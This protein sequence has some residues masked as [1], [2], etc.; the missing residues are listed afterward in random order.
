MIIL[1]D[2]LLRDEVGGEDME[3]DGPPASFEPDPYRG[4]TPGWSPL[5]DEYSQ[6]SLHVS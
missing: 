6:R 2:G 3:M 4:A 1:P 5:G